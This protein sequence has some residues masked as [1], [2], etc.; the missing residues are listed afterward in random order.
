MKLPLKLR[1]R[2]TLWYTALT[3]LAVVVFSGL[4]YL[5]VQHVLEQMLVQNAQLSLRQILAQIEAEHGAVVFENEVPVSVDSMF[6]VTEENGSELASYGADITLFDS[7]PIIPGLPRHVRDAGKEWLIL[8][9]GV[10]T[11]A[12]SGFR[13]RVALS[14]EKNRQILSTLLLTFLA[15][16]PVMLLMAVFGGRLIATRSLRPIRQIIAG[17]DRI[18]RGDLSARIPKPRVQDELG[19]LTD[20]LNSMLTDVETAF[21]REK[22]FT[23][24]ASHELRTPVAVMQA[25]T[26]N[27]RAQESTT[28]AQKAELDT[29]AAE[30]GRM[31]R[32]ITQ[33]LTITR[34]EE[35]RQ[36]L[37]VETVDLQD[38]LAG[39][40][41]TLAE[42]ASQK[43]IALSLQF[44]GNTTLQA[45]QS[46]LTELLLNLTENA[47][48]YGKQDGHVT[49]TAG[50]AGDEMRIRVQDDGIGIPQ[51]A[52]PHIFERFFRVDAARD[53]T[54]TGLGLSIVDWIV[55]AHGGVIRAESQL[56]LGTAFEITLPCD[57]GHRQTTVRE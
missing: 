55:R 23:A 21:H 28:A 29:I 31:Q 19:E 8:D 50:Q 32:I 6:F 51:D 48:K 45:D 43:N 27:L 17:A 46:L 35:G 10:I 39:I 2:M 25:Y 41:D 9:S 13:A 22:R 49:V 15:G 30:C 38:I 33:L 36:P 14:A 24:D 4:L 16:L 53:R 20:S 18:A 26:E 1:D 44:T 7:I 54:G 56:G 12:H 40:T 34:G 3:M 42:A 5:T 11:V 57:A 47:V 52:L 37:A